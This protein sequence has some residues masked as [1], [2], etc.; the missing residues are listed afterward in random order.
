MNKEN[1]GIVFH[2][3][4]VF[5]DKPMVRPDGTREGG[6]ITSIHPFDDD[7]DVIFST[8]CWPCAIKHKRNL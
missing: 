6:E 8:A 2:D 5:C 3:N 7:K 1:P 4:C